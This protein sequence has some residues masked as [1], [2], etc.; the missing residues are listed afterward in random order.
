MLAVSLLVFWVLARRWTVQSRW[1]DLA[2]WA[3]ENRLKLCT[4]NAPT[5]PEASRLFGDT[6]VKALLSLSDDQTTILQLEAA[7]P[8]PSTIGRVLRWNI[9]I[10]RLEPAW[11]TVALRPVGRPTSIPDYLP[12][13]RMY[14]TI[15]GERFAAYGENR[16]ATLALADS[17]ARGLLPPDIAMVLLDHHLMLDFSTR[18]FD[19]LT[20]HRMDA[21]AAQLLLHLPAR[22]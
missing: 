14:G 10:R 21:L 8:A 15:P 4:R 6:A 19:S 16:S 9:I 13:N 17:A 7:A 20:L 11:P 12:L 22:S 1:M 3:A 5:P 18:P 2:D